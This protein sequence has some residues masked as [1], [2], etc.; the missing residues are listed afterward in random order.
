MGGEG[1][2]TV[3]GRREFLTGA[4]GVA[5][6]SVW[7]VASAGA[8]MA[9]E[10]ALD[11]DSLIKSLLKDA[12]T[13][14]AKVKL[15]LPEVAENGNTVPYTIEVESPNTEADFVRAVHIIATGNPQPLIA[16]F[17]F[18]SLSGRAQATSRMR[19]GRSQDIVAIAEMSDGNFYS[20]RRSVKVTIGGCAG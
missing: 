15:D 2:V 11:A 20:G 18:T 8:A 14:E 9:Q 5:A 19:L 10:K 12:K 7:A 4:V 16:T 6:A 13:V 1:H 17:H 3:S